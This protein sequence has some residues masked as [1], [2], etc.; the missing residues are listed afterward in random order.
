MQSKPLKIAL[1]LFTILFIVVFPHLGLI[2]FFPM[3]YTI[4]VLLLVWLCLKVNKETFKDIGFSFKALNIKPVLIG[5]VLAVFIFL[6]MRSI[7]FPI[8]ENFIEFKEVDV[9]LYNDLRNNGTTYYI[10]MV[11]LG[12]VVGGFYESIVFHGFMFTQLEHV[13]TEK[14]KTPIS[15]IITSLLFGIYHYQLGTADM[16]NALII[17][18]GY[19]GLF[20]FYKRNLWYTI[21]CHGAYNTIAMT[22]LYLGYL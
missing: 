11:I 10:S 14:Y 6:F 8:L 5:I 19:L 7:F 17:G 15:F 4:P 9:D 13:V 20:L 16:I 1:N 21:I 2:T 3:V 12:W 22:L 18:A